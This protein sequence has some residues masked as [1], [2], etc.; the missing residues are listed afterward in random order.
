MKLCLEVVLK[1]FKIVRRGTRNLRFLVLARAF[2]VLLLAPSTPAPLRDA[3]DALGATRTTPAHVA[4][5]VR[6]LVTVGDDA[7]AGST[8]HA[9]ETPAGG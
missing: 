3:R 2:R 1:S 6:S 5:V 7:L 9:D 8:S 4:A